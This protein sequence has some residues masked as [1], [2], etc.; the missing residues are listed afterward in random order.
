MNSPG[1]FARSSCTR[2]RAAV[3]MPLTVFALSVGLV[4]CGSSSSVNSDSS[5]GGGSSAGEGGSTTG[6]GGSTTGAGGSTTGAGGSTTGAAARRSP[7]LAARRSRAP[8]ARRR[9]PA[10]PRRRRRRDSHGRWRRDGHGHRRCPAAPILRRAPGQ[11]RCAA[12]TCNGGGC[13]VAGNVCIAA[14]SLLRGR[15]HRAGTCTAGS[16]QQQRRRRRQPFLAAPLVKRAVAVA[17]AARASAP[18]RR[19]ARICVAGAMNAPAMCQKCVREWALPCCAA[20]LPRG[21]SL[22]GRPVV[23]WAQ[24]PRRPA[25]R[26]ARTA[27]CAA[28]ATCAT[29]GLGCANP[30]GGMPRTCMMCGAPGGACCAGAICQTGGVCVGAMAGMGGMCNRCGASGEACC[31]NAGPTACN[32]GLSCQGA[33]NAR[34]CAAC[35]GAGQV[36]CAAVAGG[37]AL[38]SCSTGFN[39]TAGGGGGAAAMCTACGAMAQACCGAGAIATRTCDTGLGLHGSGRGRR[40]R[41]TAASRGSGDRREAR[42]LIGGRAF[43][44]PLRPDLDLDPDVVYVADASPVPPRGRGRRE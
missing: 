27:T 23:P 15:W 7:V 11:A 44:M 1:R 12:N 43:F 29:R 30:G 38:G 26:A 37:A 41:G 39:C 33:A 9:P 19:R 42:S 13:C 31:V 10:A 36:C 24:P 20:R 17:V 2:L 25:W 40:G 18:A 14:G 22:R 35:G 21:Q 16:C 28:P 5:A 32:A 4:A 34:M 6:A 8:V 3:F